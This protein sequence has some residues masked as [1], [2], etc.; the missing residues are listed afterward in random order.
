MIERLDGPLFFAN[1]EMLEDRV[2]TKIERCIAIRAVVLDS[3]A[4]SDIDSEG[5]WVLDRLRNRVDR[6]GALLHLTTVRSPVRERLE[7]AGVWFRFVETEAVHRDVAT[8]IETLDLNPASPLRRN[9]GE[10]GDDKAQV[11]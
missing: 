3:A 10:T 8:A 7:R 4:I 6:S 1:A 5:A 11:Y 9:P 2:L